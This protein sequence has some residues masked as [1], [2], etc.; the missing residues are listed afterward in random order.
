MTD[1][2]SVRGE[3]MPRRA[4]LQLFLIVLLFGAG[5]YPLARDY[6]FDHV[7]EH[8]YTD[9][10]IQMV[11]SGNW[12][13]PLDSTGQP[14]FQKPIL[15][16]W[17]VASS[18]ELFGISTLSSRLPS[19]IF[20]AGAL[21]LT[22]ALGFRLS[23][24]RGAARLAAL[25]LASN[26]LFILAA[27]RSNPDIFLCFLLLWSSYCFADVLF[28]RDP[29]KSS[30]WHGYL[31]AGLAILTKGAPAIVFLLYVW[32]FASLAKP[33]LVL[34]RRLG[35][36]SVVA[37]VGL[38]LLWFVA[39]YSAYGADFV[40]GFWTDQ[41]QDKVSLGLL[42]TPVSILAFAGQYVL[43]FLPWC[44]VLLVA[45]ADSWRDRSEGGWGAFDSFDVFVLGFSVVLAAIFGFGRT[46][47]GHYLLPACPLIA[48]WAARRICETDTS[49]MRVALR[50]ELLIA[51]G[52]LLVFGVLVFSQ[53]TS[54]WLFVAAAA[55]VEAMLMIAIDWRAASSVGA[56]ADRLA[57]VL[58]AFFPVAAV[59]MRAWAVPD[60]GHEVE[61][62]LR[63]LGVDAN[64]QVLFVGNAALAGQIR[65]CSGGRRRVLESP[66]LP[67]ADADDAGVIV[68]PIEEVQVLA[69]RGYETG[70][71]AGVVVKVSALDVIRA[72]LRLQVVEFM[73]SAKQ[74]YVIATRKAN[75]ATAGT[76]KVRRAGR[77]T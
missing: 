47:N 77:S 43:F 26:P 11:Q 19:L 17:M 52:V 30:A 76:S 56:S 49:Q 45:I 8:L 28:G 22:Y 41:V 13:T 51:S 54:G 14:R 61:G 35:G 66:G 1:S 18:Y 29:S 62:G 58:F 12:L 72:G 65:V 68:A 64:Q 55:G 20:G 2:R 31:A 37:G 69:R 23:R 39:M 16:Y 27:L 67:P 40:R 74:R 25:V 48:S 46:L 4:W 53:E 5:L 7:D 33:R 10:A 73:E 71:A 21:L 42:A 32:V 38:P 59:L 9:A 75:A 34:L 63:G 36:V 44:L 57:I 6:L 50:F 60:F 70:A 24:S 15:T 3:R